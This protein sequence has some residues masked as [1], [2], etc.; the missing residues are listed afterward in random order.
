MAGE[1]GGGIKFWHVMVGTGLLLM[2]IGLIFI[3][4]P[5]GPGGSGTIVIDIF[6]ASFEGSEMGLALMVLAVACFLIA[7]KD[8]ADMQRYH[9]MREDLTKTTQITAK[10]VADNV[11]QSMQNIPG[12][13]REWLRKQALDWDDYDE[14]LQMIRNW[15]D[16]SFAESHA[17]R[18]AERGIELLEAL[19]REGYTFKQK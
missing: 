3:I 17:I 7:Q 19:E 13:A 12:D 18:H 2:V 5:D 4:I 15:E 11:Q 6:G 10:L 14:E 1:R 16:Q 8:R 9:S